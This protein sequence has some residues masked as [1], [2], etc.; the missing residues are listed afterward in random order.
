MFNEELLKRLEFDIRFKYSPVYFLVEDFKVLNTL[1][2][3]TTR[4]LK[5]DTNSSYV[6]FMLEF[7]NDREAISKCS[8]VFFI[9]VNNKKSDVFSTS[10]YNQRNQ[11]YG[12]FKKLETIPDYVY[13]I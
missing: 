10:Y 1:Y 5:I 11:M 3:V 8:C 6:E 12:E 4:I 2:Y 7:Q 9:D 13:Q